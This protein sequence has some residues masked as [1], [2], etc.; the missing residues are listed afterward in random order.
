[1]RYSELLPPPASQPRLASLLAHIE[2][3][4]AWCP[5]HGASITPAHMPPPQSSH[6]LLCAGR[7]GMRWR[8]P[9]R[10]FS[11]RSCST[12]TSARCSPACRRNSARCA[13]GGSWCAS[14]QACLALVSLPLALCQLGRWQLSGA[15]C[16]FCVS[17]SG[18]PYVLAALRLLG[19]SGCQRTSRQS[20]LA[21]RSWRRSAWVEKI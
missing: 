2:A 5:W 9:R 15:A 1:M 3:P 13:A 4:C 18:R 21:P 12:S 11:T 16:A 10:S 7:D 14:P 8:A 19:C 6:D 17:L 20:R